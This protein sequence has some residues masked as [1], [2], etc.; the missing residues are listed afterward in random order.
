MS[1][2]GLS[3]LR[4]LVTGAGGFVGRWLRRRLEGALPPG[5]RIVPVGYGAADHDMRRLD[6]RDAT[7]VRT[8]VTEVQPDAVFHLAAVSSV[9]EAWRAP[10]DSWAVNVTGTMNLARAVLQLAPDARFVFVGSS[11]AYGA[12]FRSWDRPL[13]ETAL[14]DPMNIYAASKA[15]ADLLIG[16]MAHEGLGAVR[17]RPF[18]HAGP[19]QSERFVVPGFAAQIARI[20]AGRQEPV[21]RVGNLDAFRDFLDVRD[22]VEAYVRVL[23]PARPLPRGS[24]LNLASGQPRRIGDVLEDLLSRSHAAIR[25]EPDP[26]RMRPSEIPVTAGA[27]RRA[28]DLLGWAPSVPWRTTLDDVLADQRRALGLV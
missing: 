2:E 5:S 11:E 22:V 7:G 28:A 23:D 10:E 9:P 15:A 21:L 24:V 16:Q 19:G 26:A 13:D 17:F 6:L 18:N 3:S 12:T 25:V 14:L 20:E 4:V 8:L 27:A 1:T